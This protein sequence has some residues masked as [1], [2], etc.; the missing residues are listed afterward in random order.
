MAANTFSAL[1]NPTPSATMGGLIL[2]GAQPDLASLLAKNIYGVGYS[3]GYT[4]DADGTVTGYDPSKNTPTNDPRIAQLVQMIQGA[5]GPGYVPDA[6]T[7]K[8]IN[9]LTTQQYQRSGGIASAG[10]TPATI[11]KLI[12]STDPKLQQAY[13]S[14]AATPQGA[15]LA[16]QGQQALDYQAPSGAKSG[17]AEAIKGIGIGVGLPAAGGAALGAF[18]PAA[19]APAA[20]STSEAVLGPATGFVPSGLTTGAGAT[21]AQGAAGGFSVI[22]GSTSLGGALEAAVGNAAGQSLIPGSLATAGAMGAPALSPALQALLAGGTGAAVAGL[23]PAAVPSVAPVAPAPVAPPGTPTP[24]FQLPPGFNQAAQLASAG[25]AAK[26]LL[27]SAGSNESG[28]SFDAFGNP[29]SNPADATAAD[30]ANNAGATTPQSQA[31]EADGQ[32]LNPGGFNGTGATVDP[33]TGLPIRVGNTSS[34]GDA[35]NRIV[36]G[37]GTPGDYLTLGIPASGALA[38]LLAGANAS[39]ASSKAADAQLQAAQAA[40]A[41]Q[42]R[43]FD[44]TQ[45]NNAPFLA[46]GTAANARLSQLLGTAPGYTGSDAGSLT[47]PFT[48][49]DLNADPVY[50]SGLQFG[51]DQGTKAINARAIAGGNYDSGATLKALT[52]FGNDYG[53]TKANDSFNRYQTQQGNTFNRLSGVSGTGQTAVGQVAQAGT[54]AANTVSGLLTDQGTARSAGIVGGSNAFTN[55]AGNINSLANNFSSNATLQALLAQRQPQTFANG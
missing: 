33:S 16:Q 34:A 29:F 13:Q 21:A 36:N 4:Y 46:T 31:A 43:Q 40:I 12:S 8:K 15:Q 55:A 53:S 27:G 24:G 11:F 45:A 37:T 47:K 39:N 41:E 30:A 54:N 22:P 2:P 50:N 7:L 35:L 18:A 28:Q 42:R 49:A 19:A 48:S 3:P 6:A 20:A 44:V 32:A 17:L 38:S 1:T 9:D 52:Q 23:A 51:L 14:F 10:N 5:A 25:A 26:A